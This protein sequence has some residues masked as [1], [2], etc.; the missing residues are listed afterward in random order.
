MKTFFG[1]IALATEVKNG[2]IRVKN[3]PD[4]QAGSK[5]AGKKTQDEF[6]IKPDG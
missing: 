2:K 6:I 4:L 1:C 5:F 3:L